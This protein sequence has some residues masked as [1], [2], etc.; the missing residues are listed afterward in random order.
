M[1]LRLLWRRM[2]QDPERRATVSLTAIKGGGRGKLTMGGS[3]TGGVLRT[4]PSIRGT[5]KKEEMQSVSS[6]PQTLESLNG[7]K[8]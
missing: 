8:E 7:E 3:I 6:P 2:D 1:T 5:R 4:Y